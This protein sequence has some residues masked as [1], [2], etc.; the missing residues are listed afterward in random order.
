VKAPQTSTQAVDET[1]VTKKI[2]ESVTQQQRGVAADLQTGGIEEVE[3]PAPYR[4]T[5]EPNQ[6]FECT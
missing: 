2:E 4:S 1:K 5:A 3:R 6:K